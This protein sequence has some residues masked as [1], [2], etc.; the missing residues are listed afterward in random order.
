[1]QLRKIQGLSSPIFNEI[2]EGG[3]YPSPTRAYKGG[4][5]RGRKVPKIERKIVLIYEI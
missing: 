1:V 5:A 4:A 3:V 2:G